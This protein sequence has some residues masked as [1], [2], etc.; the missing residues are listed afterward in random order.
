MNDR[1]H[2]S[3]DMDTVRLVISHRRSDTASP[4]YNTIG[5]RM[6][7]LCYAML[8]LLAVVLTPL[9]AIALYTFA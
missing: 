4:E 1:P 3:D 5:R 2:T 7:R 8:I 9:M 6:L